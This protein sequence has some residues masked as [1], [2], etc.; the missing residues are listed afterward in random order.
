MADR[1]LVLSDVLCFT[2][3]KFGKTDLKSLKAILN[4]FYAVEELSVAKFKLIEAMDGVEC[5]VRRP[6]IPQRRDGAERLSREVDDLVSLFTFID[7]QK[8]FD[9][10]PLYV[11]DNPDRI[12]RERLLEGDLNCFYKKLEQLDMKIEAYG[13]A[14]AAMTAEVRSHLSE[15][16]AL[17]PPSSRSASASDGCGQQWTAVATNKSKSKPPSVTATTGQS[18]SGHFPQSHQQTCSNQPD[19]AVMTSS[20][21]I[22]HSNRFAVLSTDDDERSAGRDDGELTLV[23]RKKKRQ[24]SK[25]EI[26]PESVTAGQPSRDAQTKQQQQRTSVVYG[27]AANMNTNAKVTAAHRLRKKAVFCIDNVNKH[28]EVEDIVSYVKNLSV[29]VFSCFDAVPRRQ[30]DEK[31]TGRRGGQRDRDDEESAEESADD[32]KDRKAFRLCIAAD[33]RNR[34]LDTSAWPD[35][36]RISDWYFKPRQLNDPNDRDKRIRMDRT[37]SAETAQQQQKQSSSATRQQSP[38]IAA[39]SG[40]PPTA[41]A[42]E[43]SDST[44]IE[45]NDGC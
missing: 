2:S 43:L 29:E 3:N 6:H 23:A 30:R 42:A 17:C 16:P 40:T 33:D 12:P 24:R 44:I 39:S 38:M 35:S 25:Q 7:E 34:L 11:T 1:S 28:C 32:R 18:D 37:S 9:K 4:D 27:R 21:Y 26:S 5:T 15:W 36:I 19:W 10:L 14:M 41:S 8:I 20:P 31:V 45:V 13:Q 22:R